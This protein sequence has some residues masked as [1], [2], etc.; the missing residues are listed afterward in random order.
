[1]RFQCDPAALFVFGGLFLCAAVIRAGEPDPRKRL[2]KRVF[3][4]PQGESIPY[5]LFVPKG[6]DAAKK[7]PM[8][9][10]LHGA[11]ERGTDNEAQLLHAEVLGLVSGETEA[12]QPCFLVAPQCP[13]KVK[14]VDVPW[15][16]KKPHHTPAQPTA[17]LRLALEL[18]DSLAKEF[19]IDPA[20]R[21]VTGLSMGGFGAYDACL[22]RPGYFAAAVPVCGGADDSRAKDFV[23][24][25]FWIFHGGS[26]SVVPVGRSRSIYHLL[27][28]A[29]ASVKYTE[30]PGV[31]HNSWS[32]AYREPGLAQWL[33]AQHR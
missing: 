16:R 32:R 27:K 30:Y 8:I 18:L 4:N 17:P 10:F 19:P 20:R 23:G 9:L 22:R 1:M 24:T 25:S 21:Y 12:R 31:D 15:D 13:D 26:D 33:I 28:A 3:R 29:G 5:R 11:G 2:E 7:Y 6:Y 14:W